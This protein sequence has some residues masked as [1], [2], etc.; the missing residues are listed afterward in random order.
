MPSLKLDPKKV[1]PLTPCSQKQT[2]NVGD[3][4]WPYLTGQ[5]Q[6]SRICSIKSLITSSTWHRFYRNVVTGEIKIL[7]SSSHNKSPV[8]TVIGSGSMFEVLMQTLA[9]SSTFTLSLSPA[10][11]TNKCEQNSF[12]RHSKQ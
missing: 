8:R 1:R 2:K 11:I 10:R 7:T 5:A 4:L 9:N 12:V 6:L 3:N